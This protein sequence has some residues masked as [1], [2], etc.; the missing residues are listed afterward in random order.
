MKDVM[1]DHLLRQNHFAYRN[2]SHIKNT[3]TVC[4]YREKALW[5]FDKSLCKAK[6]VVKAIR[7]SCPSTGAHVIY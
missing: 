4:E 5:E 2:V 1:R 3:K 7:L 6:K